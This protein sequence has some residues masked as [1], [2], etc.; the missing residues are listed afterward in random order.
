MVQVFDE[1]HRAKN[2]TGAQGAQPQ[3]SGNLSLAGAPAA[4]ARALR[5]RHWRIRAEEPRAK[6]LS[7]SSLRALCPSR[8]ACMLM[9]VLPRRPTLTGWGVRVS[10]AWSTWQPSW[11]GAA[12][13]MCSSLLAPRPCHVPVLR[14]A[15]RA[16]TGAIELFAMGLKSSG[17]YLSRTLSYAGAE[18]SVERVAPGAIFRASVPL[19]KTLYRRRAGAC[20]V[21]LVLPLTAGAGFSCP[22][23]AVRPRRSFLAD[24]ARHPG[25]LRLVRRRRRRAAAAAAAAAAAGGEVVLPAA[26]AAG[27]GGRGGGA[28][29]GGWMLFHST[30][31]K[32]FQQLYLAAKVL[33]PGHSP[34]CQ[35]A[36]VQAVASVSCPGV[37]GCLRGDGA[38][39]GRTRPGGL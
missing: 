33:F 28:G 16:G 32:F 23:G 11:T 5:V 14:H 22:A 31:L 15:P 19:Q 29:G 7:P 13:R 26:G 9:R 27:G 25:R 30:R 34:A 3:C 6:L 38:A 8:D 1:S 18:F 21:G 36:P 20:P 2:L 39:G 17:A 24:A 4:G 37:G 12:L 10:R 35:P